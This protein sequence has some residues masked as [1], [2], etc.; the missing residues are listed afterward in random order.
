MRGALWE[1]V[2]IATKLGYVLS[3]PT[4]DDENV[5]YVILTA[6]HVLNVELTVLQKDPKPEGFDCESLRYK[7]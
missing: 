7:I 3:G 6:T 2:A 4:K 1:T 5:N